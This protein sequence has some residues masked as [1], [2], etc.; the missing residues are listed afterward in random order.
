MKM[1]IWIGTKN[2][3]KVASVQSIFPGANFFPTSVA[4]GVPEQPFSDEETKQGAVFR[5]RKAL[6]HPADDQTIAIGLEGGVMEIDQRLYVCNWG[7][8]V[9]STDDVFVAGGARFPLPKQISEQLQQG[10]ELG[11]VMEAYTNRKNVRQHEGAIGIFTNG[12]LDRSH[13]FSHIV[14]M[15]K[16]QWEYA[17]FR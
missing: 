5:A 17:R 8:L 4:S 10:T 9:T 11:P 14:L 1:N 16:G 13:M 2:K 7:A 3:A 15:L 6:P 12:L